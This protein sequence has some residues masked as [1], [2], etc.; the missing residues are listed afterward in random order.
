MMLNG[1]TDDQGNEKANTGEGRRPRLWEALIPLVGLIVVL[2]IHLQVLGLEDPHIAI[3]LGIAMAAGMGLLLGYSWDSLEDGLVEGIQVGMKAILILMVVGMLIATWIA[4]GI[5]PLL[6]DYGLALLNPSIFYVAAC[7]ISSVVSLAT[8]SSWTTAGT[9]GV[10][11]IGVA[12]GLGLSEP[13]AAGAVV[14]GAYFGDK[15]SPLSDSTNLAPAVV[16]A[17]LFSHIRHMF[18][19]TVP[20]ML[21]SLLIYAVIGL[22]AAQSASDTE[23]IA[24]IRETLAGNF[25]LSP[26]LLIAPAMVVVMVWKKWPALPSLFGA[27]VI[28]I[29]LGVVIQKSEIASLAGSAFAG[30]ESSTGNAQV[31][32]L[33]S[34]GGLDGMMWTISLIFCALGYGGIMMKTRMLETIANGIL[35]FATSTWKLVAA[36]NISCIIM[37]LAAS[38]QYLA[39]TVPG[40]MFREAYTR[41][42]LTAR[43]LSRS[44]EDAGTLTSPLVLWNTCGATMK[45]YLGVSPVAFAP[46][47]FFNW[48]CPILSVVIAAAGWGIEKMDDLK[49]SADETSGTDSM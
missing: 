32:E 38:D 18:Y 25:N 21:I 31:D 30:Y 48:I 19:T 8:G 4:S 29:I 3:I 22:S 39:I 16:G 41:A 33:L 43:N 17:E 37:N 12:N 14:S 40:K 1:A 49:E 5:V 24:G 35:K 6:I 34:K 13:I 46:F 36:T 47:A 26:W 27:T 11:L 9:V 15:M 2:V 20:S 45:Q 10:A 42:G 28:G 23:S 7:L 44:L